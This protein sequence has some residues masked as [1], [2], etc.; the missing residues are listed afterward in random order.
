MDSDNEDTESPEQPVSAR[1]A[2]EGVRIIG[3]DE[4]AAALEAGQAAGRRPEDA[5]RFGDVPEAPEGP[6]P[7]H[8]FPLP[9]SVDPSDIARSPVAGRTGEPGPAGP[10][11]GMP[12][13]TEPPTGEVPATLGS[14][15]GDDDLAAWVG[16]AGKARWRTEPSDW[17]EVDF[18]DTAD[19]ASDLR[20]DDP[21]DPFYP[22]EAEEEDVPPPTWSR[23]TSRP[24]PPPPAPARPRPSGVGPRVATGVGV[25][26]LALLMFKAGPA[27]SLALVLVVATAAAAE[28][29]SAFRR[30]GYRPA[31]LLGLVATVSVILG[32]YSRGEAALVLVSALVTVFSLIWYLAGVVRADPVPNAA[33]TILGF[34]WVGLL[35]SFAGLLLNPSTFP[36]RHGVAFLLG[37][38]VGGVAYDVGGFVF[39][40]RVGRRQL[41]PRVSPAKT[42]EGLVGGMLTALVAC[43]IVVSQV[44]PWRFRDG[45]ALGVVVAVVAPLGDLCESMIKRD[46]GLKDMGSVLPGHG[47]VLDRVDA[48]LFVLPATYYLV[49]VLGIG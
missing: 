18:E 25:G 30:G 10:P 17:A 35:A 27:P 2:G 41:A 22:D 26:V 14:P 15:E 48:I 8:R 1:P 33:V 49:R 24:E 32:A 5:P 23:I 37:A 21:E 29:Y 34:A 47:G 20:A 4:A 28:G 42:W 43:A 44:H 6:R 31:T 38:V 7:A 45:I 3:A 19:L 11:A 13:W 39:G 36:H 40:R 16:F 9:E 46:L 12:H